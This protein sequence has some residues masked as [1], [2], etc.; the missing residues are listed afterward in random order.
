MPVSGEDRWNVCWCPWCGIRR[1][2][3]EEYEAKAVR[4]YSKGSD[5]AY[6]AGSHY[7]YL[8]KKERMRMHHPDPKDWR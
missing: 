7:S 8:A 1:Q 6:M 2:K 5:L 3:A 4:Y